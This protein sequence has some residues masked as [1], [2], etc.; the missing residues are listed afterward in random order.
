VTDKIGFWSIRLRI[1][2]NIKL[3]GL[4]RFIG[5]TVI[6]NVKAIPFEDDAGLGKNSFGLQMSLRTRHMIDIITE[7]QVLFEGTST[8]LTII[9]V[10]RH[11]YSSS[12]SCLTS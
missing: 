9:F 12:F 11:I 1:Y 6:V 7:I 5:C 10:N 2:R 4:H 8:D 3:T